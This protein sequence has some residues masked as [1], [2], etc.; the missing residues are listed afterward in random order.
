MTWTHETQPNIL[1]RTV[2]LESHFILYLI[3]LKYK[4]N[5]L[6]RC[7]EP[8]KYV[9]RNLNLWRRFAW[10]KWKNKNELA[11]LV[12]V[13]KIMSRLQPYYLKKNYEILRLAHF[14]IT[15]DLT[16]LIIIVYFSFKWRK[17]IFSLSLFLF[18]WKYSSEPKPILL[19]A[20]RP[21]LLDTFST[22]GF[23][24]RGAKWRRPL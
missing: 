18:S 7:W 10:N 23:G 9:S 3:F 13:P 6:L 15:R 19:L 8:K 11:P 17:F 2:G 14:W 4:T 20:P 22:D 1:N 12:Y 24:R 5:L 21:W 16:R